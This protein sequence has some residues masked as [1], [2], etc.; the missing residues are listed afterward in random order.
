MWLHAP[1]LAFLFAG[2]KP[3]IVLTLGEQWRDSAGVFQI[4]ALSALVQPLYETISW[5]FISMGRPAELTRI[6]LVFTPI[7]VVSF[8]LGLPFGIQGV[9]FSYS[10]VTIAAL[11][12]M[13]RYCF[14]GT[15]LDVVSVW[16]CLLR[17]ICTSLS[18][19][20][21]SAIATSV[22]SRP[23]D[24]GTLLVV[25]STFAA[26]CSLAALLPG[27]RS[28]LSSFKGLLAQLR[29]SKSS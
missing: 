10:I 27:V 11:P 3:I 7:I 9:A 28:E 23:S 8:A 5:L 15:N 19:I 21:L 4:L 6:G 20:V 17:P 12:W 14:K 1:L 26:T 25:A 29:L 13:L 2:A 18:A 22:W 16:N 24:L